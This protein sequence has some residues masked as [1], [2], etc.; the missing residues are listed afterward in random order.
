[1]ADK[2][3]NIGEIKDLEERAYW[4]QRPSF[5]TAL[6]VGRFWYSIVVQAGGSSRFSHFSVVGVLGDK[7][8]DH[9]HRDWKGLLL[10]T[11]KKLLVSTKGFIS[12]SVVKNPPANAR[13]VGSIS[14]LGRSLGEENGNPLQ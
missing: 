10:R 2:S 12:G 14:G 13:D 11:N 8:T 9:V 7:R 1:M 3:K 5:S 6:E 4:E